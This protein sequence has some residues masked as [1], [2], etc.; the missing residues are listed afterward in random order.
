MGTRFRDLKTEEYWNLTWPFLLSGIAGLLLRYLASRICFPYWL[1]KDF[2]SAFADA[3]IV[4]GVLGLLL[5]LFATRLLVQK[6]SDDLADKLVG[7]GLPT[8]LQTHI[9][10]IVNTGLV[11]D[12]FVKVYR[13]SPIAD[14]DKFQVD[15][16]INFDAK[17]YSDAVLDYTPIFQDE[18]IHEPELLSLE[19]GLTGEPRRYSGISEEMS[20][21]TK[22]KTVKGKEIIK[23]ESFRR[24]DKAI[25]EVAMRYRLKMPKNYIDITDFAGATVGAVI[26]V[27][28][29]PS[30]FEVVSSG[31]TSATTHSNGDKSWHFD[32][33][34]VTGQ[35]IRIWWFPR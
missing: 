25:C 32:Q 27:E 2:V 31:E 8:E 7:R 15:V 33:P 11:R 13:L 5:E 35:H 18:A 12:H 28:N 29:I 17:N 22:V 10:T 6:V 26:R 20:P 19:Y 1:P 34:F 16:T 9:R 4:A 23:L 30:G 14:S 21:I 3:L 24:N